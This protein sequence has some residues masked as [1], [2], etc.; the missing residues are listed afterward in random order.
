VGNLYAAFPG[1]DSCPAP[2]SAALNPNSPQALAPLCQLFTPIPSPSPSPTATATLNPNHCATTLTASAG[3]YANIATVTTLANGGSATVVET[4]ANGTPI[5]VMAIHPN[6]EYAQ[7]SY[8][9]NG[10]A[11]TG[12]A[13]VRD[14]NVD[15]LKFDLTNCDR[16][17]IEALVNI[18][19]DLLPQCTGSQ[20]VGCRPPSPS[21][22][23]LNGTITTIAAWGSTSNG[24]SNSNPACN[25]PCPLLPSTNNQHC[26]VDITSATNSNVYAAGLSSG[27]AGMFCNYE[28]ASGTIALRKRVL[29]SEG[30]QIWEYQYTHVLIR[31]GLSD[32]LHYGEYIAV[33]S[34][35]GEYQLGLG[36]TGTVAHL[37]VVIK[38]FTD[39][40]NT[41]FERLCGATT[42]INPP[43]YLNPFD[44]SALP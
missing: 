6:R 4:L 2:G 26:G 28:G 15:T 10:Q 16:S 12:W 29:T 21:T 9:S 3:V 17:K 5:T 11:R 20:L 44:G 24:C 39:S 42:A 37:H 35:L 25:S 43:G 22:T 13:K 8:T 18:G 38:V 23:V 36:Q 1:L 30:Y 27:G 19:I 33:G 34:L 14:N 7:I 32:T 31:D 40:A 41:N